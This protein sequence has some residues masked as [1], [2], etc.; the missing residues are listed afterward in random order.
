[1][2]IERRARGKPVFAELSLVIMMRERREE[3][4]QKNGKSGLPTTSCLESGG[5]SKRR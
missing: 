3:I 2:V 1:M 4:K 5:L